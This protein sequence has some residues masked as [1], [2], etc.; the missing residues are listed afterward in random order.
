MKKFNHKLNPKELSWNKTLTYEILEY[1]GSN[2][3]WNWYHIGENIKLSIPFIKK[4]L[5]KLDIEQ[6]SRNTTLT[7]YMIEYIGLH[8]KWSWRWISSH[9]NLTPIINPIKVLK[10]S[11]NKYSDI[12]LIFK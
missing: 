6:L 10:T 1:I 7:F 8:K 9:I 3:N 2:K 4:Y 11:Y 5:D 12:K